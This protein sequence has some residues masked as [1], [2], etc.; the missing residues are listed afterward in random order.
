MLL[1]K[2]KNYPEQTKL[3]LLKNDNYFQFV[4]KK[5]AIVK[6]ITLLSILLFVYT[7]IAKLMDYSL[8]RDQVAMSPILQPF[9]GVIIWALP[10]AEFFTA[11]LLIIPRWRLYGFYAACGLMLIFTVYLLGMITLN[12]RLPCSCGGIIEL[13]S[14]KQ[15]VL[16]N[17]FLIFLEFMGIRL[18]KKIN[19]EAQFSSKSY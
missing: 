10:L 11:I 18:Q 13:L 3:N 1:Q 14:W 9:A 19:L 2:W 8:F 5:I 12:R 16:I 6:I 15:H 4:M 17:C 7:G